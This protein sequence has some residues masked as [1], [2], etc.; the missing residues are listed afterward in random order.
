MLRINK[1]LD[2]A[3]WL[4]RKAASTFSTLSWSL[5]HVFLDSKN[6]DLLTVCLLANRM[7]FCLMS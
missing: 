6:R 5:L 7:R 1:A 2:L 3:T 4:S